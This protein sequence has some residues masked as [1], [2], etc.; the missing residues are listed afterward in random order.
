MNEPPPLSSLHL[1]YKV[2]KVYRENDDRLDLA[3]ER[4]TAEGRN[5]FILVDAIY[6]GKVYSNGSRR[7]SPVSAEESAEL[8]ISYYST[9]AK[10]PE[11]DEAHVWYGN[12]FCASTFKVVD[13][14]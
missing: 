10:A 14:K 1:H 8:S 4:Q 7:Q 3:T 13:T 5:V 2:S 9:V 11:T 12:V 6:L